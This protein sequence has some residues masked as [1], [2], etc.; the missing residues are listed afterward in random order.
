MSLICAFVDVASRFFFF[1]FWDLLFFFCVG[2][3]SRSS[4][5]VVGK[6]GFVCCCYVFL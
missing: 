2:L 1:D 6:D 4:F 5:D 3:G